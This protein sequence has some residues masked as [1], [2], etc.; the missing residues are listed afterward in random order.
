MKRNAIG[1][2]GFDITQKCDAPA[3][4]IPWHRCKLVETH[5]CVE[6]PPPHHS[7]AAVG[8]L[9]GCGP[10]LQ[11]SGRAKVGDGRR[12]A[13]ACAGDLLAPVYV[14]FTE[15][16]DTLDLKDAKALLGAGLT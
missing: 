8:E 14:G 10:G 16:F 7:P 6:E 3:R 15:G 11:S 2:V 1:K 12:R 5:T 13:L 9:E 4:P